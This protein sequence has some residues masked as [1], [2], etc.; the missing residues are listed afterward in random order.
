MNQTK[1]IIFYLTL[2]FF[3]SCSKSPVDISKISQP[4]DAYKSFIPNLNEQ[5]QKARAINNFPPLVQETFTGYY[6]NYNSLSKT[7]DPCPNGYDFTYKEFYYLP[8][9][10]CC[11]CVINL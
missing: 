5:F 11:I 2:A 7:N 1:Y 3:S 4:S 6:R 9:K 8:L 10:R